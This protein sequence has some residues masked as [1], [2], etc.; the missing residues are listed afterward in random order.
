MLFQRYSDP[1]TLVDK[2]IQSR[3]LNEFVIQ[4]MKLRNKDVEDK[5]IWEMWLHKVFDKTFGEFKDSV[6]GYAPEDDTPTEE[7]LAETV[8]GSMMTL[9]NF[10]PK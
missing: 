4:F 6:S 9:N 2:M 7:E 8:R 3:R 10:V 5:T 1:L